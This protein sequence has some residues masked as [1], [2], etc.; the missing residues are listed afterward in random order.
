MTAKSSSKKAKGHARKNSKESKPK[1]SSQRQTRNS[2]IPTASV[3]SGEPIAVAPPASQRTTRRTRRSVSKE[4]VESVE[5]VPSSHPTRAPRGQRGTS[6]DP[7]DSL[8]NLPD[9]PDVVGRRKKR[10]SAE[11][12]SRA[13]SIAPTESEV[14]QDERNNDAADVDLTIVETHEE[15]PNYESDDDGQAT[16]SSTIAVTQDGS[17][18]TATQQSAVTTSTQHSAGFL[19]YPNISHQSVE[20]DATTDGYAHTAQR[21][22]QNVD[23][24][25]EPHELSTVPEEPTLEAVETGTYHVN[26]YQIRQQ[27]STRYE[28]VQGD[29]Q[30][31]PEDAQLGVGESTGS[32]ISDDSEAVEEY[33]SNPNFDNY[34]NENNPYAEQSEDEEVPVHEYPA[35]APSRLDSRHDN[36][37]EFD[38]GEFESSDDGPT[39][40]YAP[41]GDSPEELVDYE[42]DSDVQIVDM[43]S[44]IEIA[45]TTPRPTF[46]QEPIVLDSDSEDGNTATQNA[47]ATHTTSQD[48]IDIASNDEDHLPSAQ[49]NYQNDQ[50]AQTAQE[51]APSSPDHVMEEASEPNS[52]YIFNN[53]NALLQEAPSPSYSA[54]QVAPIAPMG[55]HMSSPSSAITSSPFAAGSQFITSTP[56]ISSQHDDIEL[57]MEDTPI[58]TLAQYT[59]LIKSETAD[60]SFTAQ[61]QS[62]SDPSEEMEVDIT[63]PPSPSPMQPQSLLGHQSEDDAWVRANPAPISLLGHYREAI[64]REDD[65]KLLVTPDYSQMRSVKTPT[66]AER[67]RAR[68]ILSTPG[69]E[70]L[71]SSP[72][73]YTPIPP[74]P[75]P[76]DLKFVG[77]SLPGTQRTYELVYECYQKNVEAMH[78]ALTTRYD[79]LKHDSVKEIVALQ[80]EVDA[81]STERTE[82]YTNLSGLNEAHNELQDKCSNL[83]LE[84]TSLKSIVTSQEAE[85]AALKFELAHQTMFLTKTL[86]DYE[87]YYYENI[88]KKE[89]EFQKYQE[90]VNAFAA[91]EQEYP[92]SEPPLK[93]DANRALANRGLSHASETPQSYVD[94]RTASVGLYR[95]LKDRRVLEEQEAKLTDEEKQEQHN[96]A[97]A[98]ARKQ[99]ARENEINL[100]RARLM[101]DE[102]KISIQ[103]HKDPLVSLVLIHAQSMD[104]S[105]SS[106][107][108]E[109]ELDTTTTLAPSEA[110]PATPEPTTT[111]S[112]WSISRYATPILGLATNLLRLNGR[113]PSKVTTSPS[114]SARSHGQK[115]EARRSDTARINQPGP[116]FSYST[117]PSTPISAKSSTPAESHTPAANTSNAN[118]TA[119]QMGLSASLSLPR[120][121]S[122][123]TSPMGKNRLELQEMIQKQSRTQERDFTRS[124]PRQSVRNSIRNTRRNHASQA[125]P[126]SPTPLAGQKRSHGTYSFDQLDASDDERP[127]IGRAGKKARQDDQDFYSTLPVPG[128]DGYRSSTQLPPSDTTGW[129]PAHVRSSPTSFFQKESSSARV[130]GGSTFSVPDAA[131]GDENDAPSDDDHVED[132]AGGDMSESRPRSPG[133]T[134]AMPT[135]DDD[136]EIDDSTAH[137]WEGKP[138]SQWTRTTAIAFMKS[139]LPVEE[140]QELSEKTKRRAIERV[141]ADKEPFALGESVRAGD[142]HPGLVNI[143]ITPDDFLMIVTAHGTVTNVSRTVYYKPLTIPAETAKMTIEERTIWKIQQEHDCL[144]KYKHALRLFKAD[145]TPAI[146]EKLNAKRKRASDQA[147]EVSALEAHVEQRKKRLEEQEKELEERRKTLEDAEAALQAAV[148]KSATKRPNVAAFGSSSTLDADADTRRAREA[149]SRVKLASFSAAP[150][151]LSSA[152]VD[153]TDEA[154]SNGPAWTQPPPP[155]PSPAHAQLPQ[156]KQPLLS[157]STSSGPSQAALEALEREKQKANRYAPKKSSNLRDMSRFSTPSNTPDRFSVE[158]HAEDEMDMPGALQD[159][160]NTVWNHRLP[161]PPTFSPEVPMKQLSPVSDRIEAAFQAAIDHHQEE[162]SSG[163]GVIIPGIVDLADH[164]GNPFLFVNRRSF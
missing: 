145:K 131:L 106:S 12:A 45:D 142:V 141:L 111:T 91:F 154:V 143:G 14:D 116:R 89:L 22:A 137:E 44:D 58:P 163:G 136:S 72:L 64:E 87:F 63:L 92:G 88:F 123:T 23:F 35:R 134:F 100:A 68:I 60:S 46:N 108:Q 132:D 81:L 83:E 147:D 70:S 40:P 33:V 49:Y 15:Q 144:R 71:P 110:E 160:A 117:G 109:E 127:V 130:F 122:S 107:S 135:E 7:K 62:H 96:L 90:E 125:E 76:P 32:D 152:P 41:T 28:D 51:L 26:Q 85:F 2:S 86:P 158:D 99:K 105:Q 128:Q 114:K 120:A 48:V 59:P 4:S 20:T 13:T 161:T 104:V 5:Q 146:I 9:P 101:E 47:S 84:V 98:R 79:T 74:I 61:P 139:E 27:Q 113:S 93:S 77:G 50:F 151:S 103:S 24:D 156:S 126:T 148:A 43:D 95:Y 124:Q 164:G 38:S 150:S 67:L 17:S 55:Q 39:G 34:G 18:F 53:I 157:A 162:W 3:E 42:S 133:K 97:V 57:E 119:R 66:L 1:A 54:G 80:G 82:L 10:A 118:S 52:T 75:Q 31:V 129:V 155:P 94:K 121:S 153:D 25:Y 11:P 29:A 37:D 56:R 78:N 16:E 36:Y 102:V 19:A 73:H 138:F 6:K 115:S 149:A 140:R 112:R 30:A 65:G 159:T 8:F 21:A 69:A